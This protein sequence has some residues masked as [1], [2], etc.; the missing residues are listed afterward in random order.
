VRKEHVR[1]ASTSS[2][3]HAKNVGEDPSSHFPGMNFEEKSLWTG[4]FE[5]L[6][7]TLFPARLPPLELTSTPIPVPDRMAGKTNP[8]AIGTATIMNAGLLVL[9]VLAGLHSTISSLPSPPAGRDI[10]VKDFILFAP[11]SLHPARGGDGGGASAVT[12]PVTGRLPKREEMPIVPPQVPVLKN[13]TLAIDQAIS[14]PLDIKLP[15]S[16]SLPDIGVHSSLIVKLASNGPGTR[17]GIGTGSNDGDGPGNGPGSGPGSDGGFG[18]AV[19]TP[20]VGGVSKPVLLVSPE[21]EFS[22]EARRQKYQGVCIISII[23]DTRGYP[24]NFSVVRSLGL[25]LDEKALEAVQKYRFKPAMK[26][27]KPVAS[28]ATVEVNFHLY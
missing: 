10:H 8:W 1:L 7:D 6:H 16:P 5:G 3:N 12:D 24:E 15:D 14:V 4:I 19:Y 13:P 26:N 20:G 27:G 11:S 22:D 25:G 21:A 9:L 2:A 28:I 23:V 17:A 18:G